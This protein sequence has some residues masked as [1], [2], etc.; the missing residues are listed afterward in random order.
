MI[1]KGMWYGKPD[2]YLGVD[3]LLTTW[4][5]DDSWQLVQDSTQVINILRSSFEL[6]YNYFGPFPER[7]KNIKLC[8]SNFLSYVKSTNFCE[9]VGISMYANFF[10]FV[11]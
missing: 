5:A 2:V 6:N 10:K 9:N 3:D 4:G 7:P 8:D 1:V 11:I